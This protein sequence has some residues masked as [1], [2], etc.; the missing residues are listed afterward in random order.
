LAAHFSSA[1]SEIHS[2][3]SHSLTSGNKSS[4]DSY[5]SYVHKQID[6][7]NIS[8]RVDKLFTITQGPLLNSTEGTCQLNMNDTHLTKILLAGEK[9]CS[10]KTS[11]QDWEPKSQLIARTFSYWKQK[12]LMDQKKLIHFHP[13]D[14][15]RLNIHIT[16]HEHTSLV[17]HLINKQ[18]K[19]YRSKWKAQKKRCFE[20]RMK[21]LEDRAALLV[22]KMRT[23]NEKALRAIKRAEESKRTFSLY[24]TGHR[25]ATYT[26]HRH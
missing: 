21:F 5:L 22:E 24:K 25:Q 11:R 17:I 12:K 2:M 18:L 23:T 8:D 13:L 10:K 6:I 3:P 4:V 26:A 19:I 7:H 20:L 14:Q 16:D 9:Q 15:L 1:F